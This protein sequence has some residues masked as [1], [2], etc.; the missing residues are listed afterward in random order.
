MVGGLPV[1]NQKNFKVRFA[2]G[3]INP[4]FG[5]YSYEYLQIELVDL[6][7]YSIDK[8]TLKEPFLTVKCTANCDTCT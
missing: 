6:A 4:N 5:P 7:G 2:G 8:V 3:V 1:S